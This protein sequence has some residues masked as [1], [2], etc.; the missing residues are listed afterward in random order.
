M[1]GLERSWDP[2]EPPRPP[3]PRSTEPVILEVAETAARNLG[4][5]VGFVVTA[6]F[7][8]SVSTVCC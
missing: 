7:A 3:G 6:L 2:A 8:S 4:V 5:Q 1:T